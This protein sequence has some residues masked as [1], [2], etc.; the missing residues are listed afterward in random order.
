MTLLDAKAAARTIYSDKKKP[1]FNSAVAKA[2]KSDSPYAL[3][4]F[5]R[6]GFELETSSCRSFTFDRYTEAR[7]DALRRIKNFNIFVRKV[8]D[9]VM[10][11]TPMEELLKDSNLYMTMDRL[12]GHLKRR[13]GTSAPMEY[14]FRFDDLSGCR[15]FISSPLNFREWMN[16]TVSELSIKGYMNK[17]SE[18][19]YEALESLSYSYNGVG[20]GSLPGFVQN[21]FWNSDESLAHLKTAD[22]F[23]GAG[24]SW[25]P[26]LECVRDGTVSG[27]EIRTRG[28]LTV[29]QFIA[30]SKSLQ[31][32]DL[33]VDKGCSFHIHIS[34]DG[35]RL[36]EYDPDFHT[37][38]W[39]GFLRHFHT[40]PGAVKKR[41]TDSGHDYFRKIIEHNRYAGVSWRENTIEFRVF[42]N[43][44]KTKSHM[45]CLMIA[46]KSLRWA[47]RASLGLEKRVLDPK[48]S[49]NSGTFN[50]K[51]ATNV[52][53]YCRISSPVSFE[54][55]LY[56]SAKPILAESL[57]VAK[58]S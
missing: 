15:L 56:E 11:N 58:L 16:R 7:S 53:D 34:L 5:I 8:V 49:F 41:W 6:C 25:H 42:G 39:E 4:P 37:A 2:V 1:Y 38:L 13:W 19:V 52:M 27:P 40:A 43:I 29:S 33:T 55:F 48:H 32:S 22:A 17:D 26:A 35:I 12:Y 28:G 14:F 10:F 47:I 50:N 54:R 9:D 23:F 57:R 45:R 21:A 51:V 24:S 44:K 18:E 20:F 31:T 3:I 30:A 46:I 36:P